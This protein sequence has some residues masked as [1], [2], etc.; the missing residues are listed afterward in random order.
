M[1]LELQFE[2]MYIHVFQIVTD[3]LGSTVLVT[4]TITF[5]CM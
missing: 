1:D 4:V 3:I 2:T 5:W